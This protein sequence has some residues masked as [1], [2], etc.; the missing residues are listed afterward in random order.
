LKVIEEG[1]FKILDCDQIEPIDESRSC[2]DGLEIVLF[3]DIKVNE[4][5]VDG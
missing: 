1:L 2:I 4:A 3:S 5:I